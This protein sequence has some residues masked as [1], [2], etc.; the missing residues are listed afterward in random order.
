MRALDWLRVHCW[1]AQATE[2]DDIE[3]SLRDNLLQILLASN[4]PRLPAQRRPFV[5]RRDPQEVRSESRVDRRTRQP[6][7]LREGRAAARAGPPAVPRVHP[8]FAIEIAHEAALGAP[9]AADWIRFL[10][11]RRLTP[12]AVVI[13]LLSR[14]SGRRPRLEASRSAQ[15]AS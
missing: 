13:R 2:L 14:A 4:E 10:G 12:A 9:L 3:S 8:A 5:W 15:D 1:E 11:E 7:L 6:R